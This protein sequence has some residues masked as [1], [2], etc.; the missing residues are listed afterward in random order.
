M[1]AKLQKKRW[2]LIIRRA[3]QNANFIWYHISN[4]FWDRARLHK[5]VDK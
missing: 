2:L 1:V 4:V 5:E 3:A